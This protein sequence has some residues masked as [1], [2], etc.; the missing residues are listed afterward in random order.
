MSFG[1]AV[2]REEFQRLSAADLSQQDFQG[3]WAAHFYGTGVLHP[4]G[5]ANAIAGCWPTDR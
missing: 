4:S 3:V 1:L 2:A 5:G